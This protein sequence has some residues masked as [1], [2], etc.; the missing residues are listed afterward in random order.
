MHAGHLAI[1]NYLRHKGFEEVRMIVSPESPFKIGSYDTA[2]TRLAA[3]RGKVAELCPDVIVSDVEYHLPQPNYTIN[4]LRALQKAEPDTDFVIAMG[5]DNIKGIER[6]REW[7]EIVNNYEIWVYPR[8]GYYVKRLC[9]KL[10]A[11]YLED[12]KLVNISSTQIRAGKANKELM[13]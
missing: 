8:K 3:V 7:E 13:I 4:T 5:A 1:L 2:E 9:K 11:R 10:G 6:W 12:A